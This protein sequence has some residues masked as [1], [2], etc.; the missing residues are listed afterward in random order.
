MG[1]A[2]IVAVLAIFTILAAQFR[3][4]TQPLV[5]M[6]VVALSYIGVV[7]GM[8]IMDYAISMYVLYAIVG[9]AGIVVNDSLV[10]IDFV[11]QERERGAGVREAVR[12]ASSHRFRPIL[13]TTVTTVA[14][15]LPM[16]MGLQG[17][18]IVFGPF[19]S[20]IVFGLSVASGLT[21]F[22]VPSLYLLLEDAKA[23]LGR[24]RDAGAPPLE[25]GAP[26]APGA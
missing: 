17:G 14:G 3:S 23:R 22:V 26:G 4:Y 20:A 10:L 18:S 7:V 12:T 25:I 16:A 15:L 2:F 19:A 1:R 8:W 13:L 21:L 24:G 5:V 9:L 6:S 11:N